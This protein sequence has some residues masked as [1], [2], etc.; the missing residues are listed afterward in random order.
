MRK[1]YGLNILPDFQRGRVWTDEQQIAYI[2]FLLRG[3]RTGRDLFF[4]K[5]S[6]DT[7][8]P[9]GDYDEFVCVDGLQRLTA[10]CRFVNNEIPAFGSY[11]EE[12]TDLRLFNRIVA[13]VHINDLKTEREV[14]QWYL[15]INDG[16]TPH[17]SDE[18]ERVRKLLEQCR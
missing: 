11:F 13:Q 16:G 2:V 1:D 5:P 3:G 8:V 17:T 9:E 6:W 12:Y 7:N 14:L 15:D 4:N 10:M 18:I